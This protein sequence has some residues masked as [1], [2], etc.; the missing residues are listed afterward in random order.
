MNDRI[1]QCQNLEGECEV[2][3]KED[4]ASGKVCR[5]CDRCSTGV[6][7]LSIRGMT[8]NCRNDADNFRSLVEDKRK[9][10]PLQ[11]RVRN[12]TGSDTSSITS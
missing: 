7:E 12:R 3:A 1:D 4:S 8:M 11:G 2:W 6:T 10:A 5:N 9:Q